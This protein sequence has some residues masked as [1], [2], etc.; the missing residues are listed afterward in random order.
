MAR[1]KEAKKLAVYL[2]TSM[3]MNISSEV[4]QCIPYI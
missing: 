3:L 4:L 2:A 1:V